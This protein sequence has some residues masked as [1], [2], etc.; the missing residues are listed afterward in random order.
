LKLLLL[1]NMGHLG[2]ELQ[3]TLQP[4]GDVI[5]FD[6]PEIDLVDGIGICKIIQELNPQVIVNA[7][8]YTAV[9]KAESEPELAE[10]IN[11]IG[12]GI[13]AE[14]ARKLDAF[15]I[16]YSTDYVFDGK[17]GR[18]YVET[19][20]ANPLNVY[21]KTKLA[22][23]QAIQSVDGN[24]M[25]LRTA[26]VYS[27]RG[28]SYLS[29]VLGWARKLETLRVVD[30]QISNPTWARM[31]AEITAQ[32]LARGGDYIRER[33]GLYHL[34][35]GGHASRYTWA[36]EILR[37]DPRKQEQTFKQLLPVPS[38]DFSNPT[39][40]PLFSALD[41]QKFEQAFELQLPAWVRTLEMALES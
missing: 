38:S 35:G 27:R 14:E 40:R 32:A 7:T 29:K 26:W 5:S 4:L 41:C 23:D 12:P 1:G 9:D 33:K 28:D 13:L 25:I 17:K 11:A 19:D 36:Q 21:G 8:A 16:H 24:Y 3:R 2:W 31:L 18:P 34:A 6:Y 20:S 15:L 22:G 39:Q 10:K 30:D 37:L